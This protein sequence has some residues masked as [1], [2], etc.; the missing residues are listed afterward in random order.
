MTAVARQLLDGV[1]QRAMLA[2]QL[3]KR[4]LTIVAIDVKRPDPAGGA[5]RDTNIGGRI[6]RPPV[7]DRVVNPTSAQMLKR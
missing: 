1:G 6:L 7:A 3:D 4:F 2:S 5:A